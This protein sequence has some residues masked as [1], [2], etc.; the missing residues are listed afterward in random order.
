M[1]SMTPDKIRRTPPVAQRRQY[2]LTLGGIAL[3]LGGA[4]AASYWGLI[5]DLIREWS[6][7]ENYSVGMLVPFAAIYLAWQDR[8]RLARLPLRP[9]WW[10]VALILAAQAVRMFGLMTMYESVERYSLVLTIA[11][12]VLLVAGWRIFRAE[13]WVLAFLFLMVP[14]PG[15][16]HNTISG[17]LQGVA[18][19][20]AVFVLELVG[21][22]VVREGHTLLLNGNV[23]VAVAEACSGLRMLTAFVVVAW[24][25][26]YIIHRSPWQKAVVVVSSIP[27]AILCNIVRLVIT[28]MLFMVTTAE[29][30]EQFFHDFA[31]LTMMPLAILL[32]LGE[33]W[34]MSQIVIEEEPG[35]RTPAGL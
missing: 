20:G 10:G 34:V 17:P 11:G 32:L 25:L 9:C 5:R 33:L 15:R 21:V 18:T 28:A 16:I 24:V 3:V 27:V 30:A 7:D 8:A 29:F 12:V 19:S 2:L 6:N 35:E 1:T 31:G 4:L 23:H 22:S 13:I 14:L 26:A